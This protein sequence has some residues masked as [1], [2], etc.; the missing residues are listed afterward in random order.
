M[1]LVRTIASARRA[2]V[3]LAPPRI[4]VPT[5][6]ALHRGHVALIEQARRRA[7]AK[8]TVQVSIFINPAQFGPAEDFTRYPR[9]LAT[10]LRACRSAGADLIFAPSAEEMYDIH[11]S[12]SIAESP[13]STRLCGAS[14]PGH[15]AGVCTVVAKLFNILTPDAALFGEKDWQQLVIIRRMVADLDFPVKVLSHPTIREADG[16]ALSS[17]NAYLTA[18]ERA[19]APGIC[20][21]LKKAAAESPTPA[22]AARLARKLIQRIPG[23]RVDY[24]EGVDASTLA[25]T[26][27]TDRPA[28]LA[29]AV[30]F[31]DTRLIDNIPFPKK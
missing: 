13:L 8:G 31:G 17:R 1:K 9:M 25:S 19:A 5:M 24:V 10:D 26:I 30:Y 28:R 6:G 4:L 18:S 3:A 14:R 11:R 22:A 21:A 20:A 7:G 23:A 15:F 16:L 12:V 2:T 29:A 27:R